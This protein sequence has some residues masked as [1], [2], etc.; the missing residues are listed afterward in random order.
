MS[1]LKR[2]WQAIESLPSLAAVE[3][4]WRGLVGDEYDRIKRFLRPGKE[5]ASSFPHPAGGLPL[6]VIEHG[7]DDLVGVCQETGETIVLQPRQL[8]VY[9]LDQERLARQ[10]ARALGLATP[11]RIIAPDTRLFSLGT[12]RPTGYSMAAFLILPCESAEIA[13]GTALLISQ[14]LSPFLLLTP[15][16]RFVTAEVDL[17]LRS[18]GSGLLPLADAVVV[19]HDGRWSIAND[20][21][22]AALPD[23]AVEEELLSNRAQSVLIAMLKLGALDSDQRRSTEEI[24]IKALGDATDPNALKSVMADL[25]TRKLIQTREGRGGGCWLTE[26]GRRRA[27]KLNHC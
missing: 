23:R 25:K 9:R 18:L 21:I 2:F 8:V 1:G 13:S 11:G 10:V 20:T 19:S 15:T 5:R 16:R 26:A 3:A 12:F 27:E 17:R 6:Q 24:A 7:R 22:Q 4:E 14:G